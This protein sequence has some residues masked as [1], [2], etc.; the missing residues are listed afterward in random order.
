MSRL[1]P[2]LLVTALGLAACASPSQKITRALVAYG[3][4]PREAQCMG[5]KLGQRLSYGQLRRIKELAGVDGR[6]L[7][8]LTIRQIAD[9]LTDRRDPELVAELLRAGI[10]CA[11]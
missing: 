2:A 4:P 11:F 3:V 6:Q 1:H 7:S 8:G 9:K 5:D 10:A